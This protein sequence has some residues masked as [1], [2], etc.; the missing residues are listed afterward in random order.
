MGRFP[1]ERKVSPPSR[2]DVRAWAAEYLPET[3]RRSMAQACP[4]G[5]GIGFCSDPWMGL[6]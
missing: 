4:E 1:S 5:L 2:A 3:V 6:G